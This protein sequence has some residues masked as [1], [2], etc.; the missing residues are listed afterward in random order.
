VPAFGRIYGKEIGMRMFLNPDGFAP[1]TAERS[2]KTVQEKPVIR[3]SLMPV[4]F[5]AFRLVIYSSNGWS[6]TAH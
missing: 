1:E 6:F 5:S 3:P 4:F 2:V